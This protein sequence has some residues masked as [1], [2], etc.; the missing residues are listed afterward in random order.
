MSFYKYRG[1]GIILYYY[2]WQIFVG[3]RV[4]KLQNLSHYDVIHLFNFHTDWAPHFLFKKTGKEKL[5]WGPIAHHKPVPLEFLRFRGGILYAL[6]EWTKQAV[7]HLF[8][9]NPFLKWASGS[10]YERCWSSRSQ[11]RWAPGSPVRRERPRGRRLPGRSAGCGEVPSTPASTQAGSG[12]RSTAGGRLSGDHRRYRCPAVPP[13]GA[14]D[15]RV[16]P[17]VAHHHGR[18]PV[19]G[20]VPRSSSGGRRGR[21]LSHPA[22]RGLALGERKGARLSGP[23][24]AEELDRRPGPSRVGHDGH[25]LERRRVAQPELEV[26]PDGLS[27]VVVELRAEDVDEADLA[28]LLRWPG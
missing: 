12:R 2:F 4:R 9:L 25:P 14:S 18:G 16:G 13:P 20:R 23:Q 5:V 10:T 28:E 3:L 26:L 8:W 1:R 22:F 19:P 21:V 27:L 24:D 11:S 17:H 7:K 6:K 15:R